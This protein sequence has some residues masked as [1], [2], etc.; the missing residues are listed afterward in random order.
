MIRCEA[1]QIMTLQRHFERAFLQAFQLVLR[2]VCLKIDFCGPP[3]SCPASFKSQPAPTMHSCSFK[4]NPTGLTPKTHRTSEFRRS[5]RVESA[6]GKPQLSP[7]KGKATSAGFSFAP[8]SRAPSR[9]ELGARGELCAR[10]GESGGV[11]WGA[12]NA[13]KGGEGGGGWCCRKGSR[14]L[15]AVV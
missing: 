1:R 3:K 5:S 6:C 7:A 2:C 13:A 12:K 14:R 15:V 10:S 9:V 11:C 4:P 8:T